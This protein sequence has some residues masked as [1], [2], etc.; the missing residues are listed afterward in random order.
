ML[1]ALKGGK[2]T[3]EFNETILK[4]N[5]DYHVKTK[6]IES[7]NKKL[8]ASFKVINEK[9]IPSYNKKEK[10]YKIILKH[11]GITENLR[12]H[13]N[14][15]LTASSQE[16]DESISDDEYFQQARDNDYSSSL[17]SDE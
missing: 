12:K 10:C 14:S 11:I 7:I 3:W 5:E 16:D 6:D 15:I 2:I 1:F 13:F 4:N 8:C 17:Y 9:P